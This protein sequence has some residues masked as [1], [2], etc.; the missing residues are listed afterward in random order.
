MYYKYEHKTIEGRRSF[1]Y[2]SLL[3]IVTSYTIIKT[4]LWQQIKMHA[5]VMKH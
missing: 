2:V 1:F 5:Y 4:N 3:L